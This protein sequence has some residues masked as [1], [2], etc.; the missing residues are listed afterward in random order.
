MDE[1][2]ATVLLPVRGP[3]EADHVTCWSRA[4]SLLQSGATDLEV[5]T[6]HDSFSASEQTEED[7]L[8]LPLQSKAL[9]IRNAKQRKMSSS[10]YCSIKTLGV[11][12]Y[13]RHY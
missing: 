8:L 7:I 12:T 2:A 3:C 13:S 10:T 1:I 5:R 9:Q 6:L 11:A 4:V